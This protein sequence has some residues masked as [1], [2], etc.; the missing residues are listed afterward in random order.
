MGKFT[1]IWR[2]F[3]GERLPFT[4]AAIY[5]LAAE[6]W[7]ILSDRLLAALAADPALIT[8]LESYKG[9]LFVLATSLL[10]LWLLRLHTAALRRED[11]KLQTRFSQIST[12]F[13]SL[14]AVVYVAALED[15]RVLYMNRYGEALFGS[16]WEG[17]RCYEVVETGLSAPCRFFTTERLV[18][19]GEPQPAE[20]YEYRSSVNGRWYQCIDRA[21]RWTDGRLVRMEIAVDISERKEMER[22]KDEMISAVSHEMRTPLT[23]MLGFTEFLLENRVEEAELREHLAT[24]HRETERLNGLIS[25]FLDLQRMKGEQTIYSFKTLAV[26]PLLEEAAALFAAASKKHR[27]TL[28]APPELPQVF[29]DEARL[30]QVLS[31]L[32]SNAIKYSPG[33][34]GIVLG[35]RREGETVTLWVKDEGIGIPSESLEKIFDRFYRVDG[36]DQRTTRGTGLG[37]ALVR[38]IVQAHGGRLWVESTPGKGST[39]YMALPAWKGNGG[40]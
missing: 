10:L 4:I 37:L 29:G 34:G 20:L 1:G 16:G 28:D 23:A 26:R 15:C 39:F 31:N 24:I 18:R 6:L 22:M 8:T 38:E 36:A 13:D 21:I 32:L 7:I 14:N 40:G 3:A 25:N 2:L 17:K 9:L 11:E 30:H 12:I 5:A 33:G 19:E 35:A 27:I